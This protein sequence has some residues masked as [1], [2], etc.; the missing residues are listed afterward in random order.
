MNNMLHTIN[1]SP[2]ENNTLSSCFSLIAKDSSV[3]LIEDAAGALGANY[4]GKNVGTLSD[5]GILVLT[6][7]K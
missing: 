4:K 7:I 2:F 5:A 1:K 3:I 6:V